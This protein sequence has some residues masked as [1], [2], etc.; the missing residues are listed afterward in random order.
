MVFDV[1][2]VDDA[3]AFLEGRMYLMYIVLLVHQDG[4]DFPLLGWAFCICLDIGGSWC[5]INTFLEVSERVEGVSV[6]LRLGDDRISDCW[7]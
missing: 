7:R 6:G 2:L 4:A 3:G 5:F 1:D